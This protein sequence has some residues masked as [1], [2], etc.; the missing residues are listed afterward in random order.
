MSWHNLGILQLKT[1]GFLMHYVVESVGD[2]IRNTQSD[3]EETGDVS[4]ES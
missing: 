2:C 1:C 4:S 3:R